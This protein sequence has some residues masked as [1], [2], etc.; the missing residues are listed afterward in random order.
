MESI[1]QPI[2][3]NCRFASTAGQSGRPP[4][5]NGIRGDHNPTITKRVIP[6]TKDLWSYYQSNKDDEA[7]LTMDDV[8][9]LNQGV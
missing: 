3:T 9:T 6:G 2:F 8:M 4:F 7:L 5:D 1:N